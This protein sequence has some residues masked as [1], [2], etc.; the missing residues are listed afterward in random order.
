MYKGS[1]HSSVSKADMCNQTTRVIKQNVR[2]VRQCNN[3]EVES[4][5]VLF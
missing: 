5:P 2:A 3:R 4:Q 1:P